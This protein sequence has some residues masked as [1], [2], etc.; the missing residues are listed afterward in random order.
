MSLNDLESGY[1][2]HHHSSSSDNDSCYSQFHSTTDNQSFACTSDAEKD[3]VERD[4]RICQL[5]LE[6]G[7]EE[8]GVG[9]ELGCSC[10]DDLGA[11][12]KNCAE[13]WFKIKGNKTCE[14]CNSIA[15]NVFS[16]NET[17]PI[18]QTS[19]LN[20]T[21]TNAVPAQ[22]YSSSEGHSCFNGHRFVN[23]LLAC[24]VFIF[25]I[26]WLFHFDIPS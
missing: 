7:G 21:T 23:F 20:V 19:D 17:V 11:A 15:R 1:G 2:H 9:I 24:M 10:K 14:I 16:A 22:E 6:S 13:A 4:C 26:S 18:Q 8:C 25:V 12:H 3:S 5:G